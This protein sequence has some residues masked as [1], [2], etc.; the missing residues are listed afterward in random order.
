MSIGRLKGRSF[1]YGKTMSEPLITPA[2]VYTFGGVVSAG[3]LLGMPA[4]AVALGAIASAAVT[5]ISE[6]KSR[7]MVVAHIVIGGLLG[8]AF[9][10]TVVNILVNQYASQSPALLEQKTTLAQVAAP[11]FVGL[12]WQ[13]VIKIARVLWPAFEKN[14][15]RLVS[16]VLDFILNL[17]IK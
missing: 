13:L 2:A 12:M 7:W 8:G 6:P 9:A 5:M 10:P 15:D 14:A 11:V 4:D 16:R 3:T 1:F 17:R